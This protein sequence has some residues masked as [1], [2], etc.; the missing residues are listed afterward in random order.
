MIARDDRRGRRGFEV[1][2]VEMLAAGDAMNVLM[3]M[4]TTRLRLRTGGAEG[5]AFALREL[6]L[7]LHPVS[8]L[9]DRPLAWRQET[10]RKIRI[11]P[12]NVSGD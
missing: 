7:S 2:L 12:G 1:G 10:R 11:G 8:K 5:L 4:P 6:R 3:L 9:Q